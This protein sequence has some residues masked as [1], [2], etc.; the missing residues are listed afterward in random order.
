MEFDCGI[1]TSFK[2][3]IILKFPLILFYSCTNLLLCRNCYPILVIDQETSKIVKD[4]FKWY[5]E[6]IGATSI[7]R[8]L[9]DKG[10]LTGMN[11][12]AWT[13]RMVIYVL[14][15]EKYAGDTLI[16]KT[17]TTEVLPVKRH[18]NRGERDKYYISNTHEP[19]ISKVDF[20]KVQEILSEQKE[21]YYVAAKEKHPL[22]SM[23]KCSYCNKTY[24][25]KN[26]NGKYYWSCITHDSQAGLC[27]AHMILEKRIY[28]AFIKLCNKLI[29][30]SGDI[31]IPLRHELKELYSTKYSSNSVV[32][33]LRRDIS[34]IN[35]QNSNVING[36]INIDKLNSGE[37]VIV[38]ISKME[39]ERFG[40]IF[41]SGDTIPLSDILLSNEEEQL[42][43]ASL[44]PSKV[45]YPVYKNNVKT[46]EGNDI[47]LTSYAFGKRI[48]IGAKVGAVVVLDDKL[49]KRYLVFAGERHYGINLLCTY[50]EF[51]AWGMPNN[52]LT[53]LSIKVDN[54]KAS[55]REIDESWYNAICDAKGISFSSS[56]D[57]VNEVISGTRKTMSVY[58]CIIVMLILQA[59][60][61]TAIILYTNIR[62]K[63]RKFAILR[64]CGMSV[65]QL[66]YIVIKSNLIYPLIGILF[67]LIPTAICN[68]FLK[69]ISKKIMSGEWSLDAISGEIPWYLELPWGANL[70][71]YKV[72]QTMIVIF[73][74]Y[75]ILM[76][77]VTLPQMY[78]ISKRTIATE[79]DKSEF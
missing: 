57:I 21:K 52:K 32:M 6:G 29:I 2:K 64:A 71:S 73:F 54:N 62:I 44:I 30:H 61:M 53:D 36:S 11:E 5:L 9:N 34:E 17:F 49:T 59:S 42:D 77:M 43:F 67:S 35:E 13:H 15:N 58:Y 26:S 65:N 45:S 23:I 41:H 14:T 28:D 33:D 4:I 3:S 40:S 31:L 7:A 66:A 78:Y 1:D 25:R 37:E 74:A 38:A 76:L 70:F 69:Y 51:S 75:I 20:D 50:G 22:G 24:R 48:N 68:S 39:E 47:E 16:Q 56:S 72:P 19:I 60:V 27:P 79:L 8:I 63:S 12:I 18:I 46:P 55:V 10:I